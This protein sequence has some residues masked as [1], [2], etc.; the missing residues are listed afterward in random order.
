MKYELAFEHGTAGATSPGARNQDAGAVGG[1]IA[2]SARR[3]DTMARYL[4]RQSI[5]YTALS[6][7]LRPGAPDSVW[8]VLRLRT[9]AV[10]LARPLDI[11]PA[12]RPISRRAEP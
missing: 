4:I 3:G 7:G 6:I 2:R 1:D 5:P 11:E 10:P 8:F 12:G 9:G